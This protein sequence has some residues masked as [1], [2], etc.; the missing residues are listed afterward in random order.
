MAGSEL[1]GCSQSAMWGPAAGRREIGWCTLHTH[2][3]AESPTSMY[4]RLPTAAALDGSNMSK[5]EPGAD[6]RSRRTLGGLGRSPWV[7]PLYVAARWPPEPAHACS[8][9]SPSPT[10]LRRALLS[11]SSD[12]EVKGIANS[13]SVSVSVSSKAVS[14]GDYDLATGKQSAEGAPA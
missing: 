2:G 5:G 13:G 4:R 8:A 3:A 14:T 10:G 9:A 7:L 11:S 6:A 12:N 1:V